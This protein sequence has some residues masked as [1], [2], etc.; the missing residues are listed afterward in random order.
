MCVYAGSEVCPI[1]CVY[2]SWVMYRLGV[3]LCA[4]F[5]GF[6]LKIEDCCVEVRIFDLAE[7]YSLFEFI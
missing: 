4:R 7:L 6:C 3:Q 2:K 5:G 1:V